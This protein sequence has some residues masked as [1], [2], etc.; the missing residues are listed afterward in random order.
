MHESI[1]FHPSRPP[2]LFTLVQYDCTIIGEYTTPL[3]TSRLYAIHHTIFVI[4]ISCKATPQHSLKRKQPLRHD[5][6]FTSYFRL[7]RGCCAR[8]YLSSSPPAHLH[9]LLH[10]YW[11]VYDS[12]PDLPFV[13]YTPYTIRINDIV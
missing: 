9:G 8:I 11:T 10:D 1:I 2:A 5:L 4:T 6:A 13:C 3:P 7:H 12:P